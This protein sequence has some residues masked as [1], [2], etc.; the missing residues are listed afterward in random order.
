MSLV[1]ARYTRAE[2]AHYYGGSYEE[3][4]HAAP[5]VDPE[6]QRRERRERRRRRERKEERRSGGRQRAQGEHQTSRLDEAI[7]L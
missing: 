7:A 3:W 1:F 5:Y 6:D 2:F 4:D